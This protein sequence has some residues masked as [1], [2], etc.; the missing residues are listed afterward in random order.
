MKYSTLLEYQEKDLID[1]H[2]W[3]WE[4]WY[5]KDFFGIDYQ[6]YFKCIYP[7]DL[8]PDLVYD[9]NRSALRLTRDA[10][11]KFPFL[12]QI[13]HFFQQ[14]ENVSFLEGLSEPDLL[15]NCYV[16]IDYTLD[17][18]GY[19]LKPHLDRHSKLFTLQIYLP[20]KEEDWG[21]ELYN[22]DMKLCSTVPFLRN[23][24][25]FTFPRQGNKDKWHGV[26]RP[27]TRDRYSV[28]VNYMVKPEMLQEI[29][30]DD[31]PDGTNVML[32]DG[33]NDWEEWWSL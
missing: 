30:G 1:H 21:T 2:P 32:A 25:W 10:C 9:K 14:P 8:D 29:K 18:P 19:E 23:C 5:V 16:R 15:K 27:I 13:V 4:H 3:P 17:H 31:R 22:E 26:T 28:L 6:Q 7:E 12:E 20:D 11:V 33:A 24:G